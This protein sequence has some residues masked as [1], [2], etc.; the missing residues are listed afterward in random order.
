MP[1]YEVIVGRVGHRSELRWFRVAVHRGGATV[2][3]GLLQR[4]G[5]YGSSWRCE[6][7]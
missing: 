2:L 1:T 3:F 5:N 7:P 6:D 4:S